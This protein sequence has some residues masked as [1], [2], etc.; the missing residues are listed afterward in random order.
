MGFVLIAA[1][2][3]AI[4]LGAVVLLIMFL[5]QLITRP[6]ETFALALGLTLLGMAQAHPLAGLIILG[7]IIATGLIARDK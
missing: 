7:G 2:K 5:F 3:A 6:A 4:V 1:F